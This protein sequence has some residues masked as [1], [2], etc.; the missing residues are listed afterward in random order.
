MLF[1]CPSVPHGNISTLWCFRPYKP[2]IFWKLL[3]QGYQNWYYQVSHTQIHK[4]KYTNTQIQHI[5][6]AV[7]THHVAYFWKE[8]CSRIS[9]MIF[10]CV[11][12]ANTK[13]QIQNTQTH[14]YSIWRSARKT[15]HVVYFWREDCS[16]IFSES[17]MV[18]QG[19]V[20]TI[21][22]TIIRD[23]FLWMKLQKLEVAL[24]RQM[25]TFYWLLWTFYWLLR[26]LTDFLLTSTVF[27]WLSSVLYRLSTDY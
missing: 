23:A 18:V 13:I 2:Y 24:V 17:R 26:I 15:Q 5:N 22:G 19:L 12:H 3:V 9:K 25:L 7:K 1:V 10:P 11:K 21:V 16:W 27:Y 14:K 8:D 4:Y 20:S 6:S